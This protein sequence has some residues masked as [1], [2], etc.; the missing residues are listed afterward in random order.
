MRP[1]LCVG[2]PERNGADWFVQVREQLLA[3]LP[4]DPPDGFALAYEPIWAIGSGRTPTLEEIGD[5]LARLRDTL[6]ARIGGIGEAVPLLYG[7]SV[8][9]GNAREICALPEVG[10]LLIGGAS[11]T[12]A[13]MTA[14]L[15]EVGAARAVAAN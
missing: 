6:V 11:L 13:S 2:E 14:I 3:S 15:G 1:I 10:G 4:D 9:A 5:A 7:G 12:A 8:G